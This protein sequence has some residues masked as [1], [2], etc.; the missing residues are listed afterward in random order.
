MK[1]QTWLG[2][3]RLPF[4]ILSPIC[5]LLGLACAIYTE[6]TVNILHFIL[7]MIAAVSAHISVN[8]FNEY[9]DF[10]S[11]LDERTSRT[12]FSGGS[13]TLP[14]NPQSAH[15][16]LIIAWVTFTISLIIGIYFVYLRGFFMFFVFA[17]SLF[18][19]LTYTP[20][21][22]RLPV[23][24]LLAP[25]FGF[26]ISMVMGTAF[27]LTGKVTWT[28]FFA[29]LIP[30]FLV[31]NLLLLNQFPDV[32]ADKSVGRKNYPIILGRERSAVI[33]TSFIV[34]TYL[35]LVCGVLLRFLPWHSLL[36]AATIAIAFP[37]AKGVKTFADN[38]PQLTRYLGFNVVLNLLT[39]LFVALG[40]FISYGR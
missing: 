34:L 32:E 12:P 33:F 28:A 21:I 4:V 23:F 20:W 27:A 30:F 25:G 29:S 19:I 5:V 31:N 13:G 17:S 22:T 37:L 16:A 40:L 26:G 7:F 9:L 6:G 2:P 3:M 18:I 8:A 14:Q 36:A 15:H 35:S 38:I 11:G 24:S 39:P 10:K 1:F